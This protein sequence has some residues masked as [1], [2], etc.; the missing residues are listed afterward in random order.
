MGFPPHQSLCELCRCGHN[1]IL[2]E[3][4]L[5]DLLIQQEPNKWFS[6]FWFT[7]KMV[8]TRECPV[9]MTIVIMS[10]HISLNL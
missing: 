6:N 1:E 9:T 7:W 8:R 10:A 5:G 4:P 2:V 3:V